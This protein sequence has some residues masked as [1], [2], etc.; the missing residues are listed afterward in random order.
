M[1]S[2]IIEEAKA[3]ARAQI[4]ERILVKLNRYISTQV[5][6]ILQ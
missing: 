1:H 3:F 4:Q 5:Y 6:S 2:N